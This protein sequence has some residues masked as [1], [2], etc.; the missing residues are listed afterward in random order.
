M[1]STL[2]KPAYGYILQMADASGGNFA[3]IAEVK[4]IQLDMTAQVEDVT[5]HSTN[6]P[7]RTRITTLLSFGPVTFPINWA[8]G[9]SSHNSTT[10]ILSVFKGRLERNFKLIDP[11][12][13][14]LITFA[15]VISD[16]KG[17]LPVAGVKGATV[18][19]QGSGAPTFA[20]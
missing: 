10:G 18:T 13:G 12:L 3:T 9:D 19:I 1:S 15:G 7:W 17:G 2:A 11:D 16:M 6:V 20:I 5:S 4:D 8:P 14:T